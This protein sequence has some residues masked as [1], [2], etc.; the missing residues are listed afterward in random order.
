MELL[1]LHDK[2]NHP[3]AASLPQAQPKVQTEK[4]PRPV[5]KM[6]IG[7]E[8]F[9]FFQR[10]WQAYKRSCNLTDAKEI[11]DQLLSACH[12][13][14][15]RDLNSCFGSNAENF[16]KVQLLAEIEKLAVLAQNNLVNVYHLLALHQEK[17]ESVRAFLARLKAKSSV[18]DLVVP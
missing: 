16:T 8:E 13:D 6:G 9:S 12:D 14:L 7:L 4:V 5:V 1:K 3:Q 15:A 2:N 10:R 18:C 11:R 17:E